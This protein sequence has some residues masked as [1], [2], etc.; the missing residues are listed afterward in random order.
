MKCWELELV[1]DFAVDAEV[2]ESRSSKSTGSTVDDKL[3]AND[4]IQN[5]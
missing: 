1:F 3:V 4:I 2:A 5:H